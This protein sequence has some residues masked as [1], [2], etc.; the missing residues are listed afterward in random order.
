MT[1]TQILYDKSDRIATITLNR[2]EALNAYTEQM[3]T[4]MLSAFKDAETDTN[5]GA[6]VLAG[7]GRAFCGGADVKGWDRDVQDLK[8]AVEEKPKRTLVLPRSPRDSLLHYMLQMSKPILAA[9]HSHAV[10]IGATMILPCDIRIVA[11]TARIGFIFVRRGVTP[12][13]GS[14]YLLPRIVG[15]SKAKE[16]CLTARVIGAQEAKEIGLANQIVPEAELL[17]AAKEMARGIAAAPPI[18][19]AFTKRGLNL[20]LQSTLDQMLEFEY[21]AFATCQNSEDFE[22]SVRAFV[23]KREPRF[24]GR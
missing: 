3:G 21:W 7:A 6:V 11:E 10:G 13:F 1:Y 20:S 24:Q 12:E 9:V 2:P 19:I 18:A 8:K 22:E 16:L 23:E 4:E 17:S 5:V 14:T 15:F